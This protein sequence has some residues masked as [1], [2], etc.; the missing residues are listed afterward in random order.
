MILLIQA[1]RRTQ[2]T[3][4]HIYI[5]MRTTNSAAAYHFPSL[6]LNV[7]KDCGEKTDPIFAQDAMSSFILTSLAQA[8]YIIIV[9]TIIIIVMAGAP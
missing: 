6:I 3:L 2:I 1:I 8:L 4:E 9:I 5:K 7:V